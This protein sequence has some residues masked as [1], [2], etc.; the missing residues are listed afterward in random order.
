MHDIDKSIDTILS[1]FEQS[2]WNHSP[3]FS[4][5]KDLP[6]LTREKIRTIP[7][8]KGLYTSK[9]SGSTGEPVSIEKTLD[10]YVWYQATNIR[11]LIWRRWNFSKN[12]AVI[13][14]DS[15]PKPELPSWGISSRIA[16]KQGK[17]FYFN[18]APIDQ[19]QKWLEEKNP[20]YIQCLPSIFRQLDISKISNFID[21]KGTGEMGASM[22]SSEECGTIAIQ[23]PDNKNNYH[24]ME[25]QIVETDSDGAILI[26]TLTNPYIRRYKHGDHV[27]LGTCSCGRTLQT[28]TQING[29]VRNMFVMPDGSKKWPIFGSRTYYE[30]YGILRYKLIQKTILD[31]EMQ[32][33][34]PKLSCDKE[35][36]LLSEVRHL[37]GV[38][39]HLTFEYVDGFSDYKFEEFVSLV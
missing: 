20:H 23:C 32:L 2:Q 8:K 9:T 15:P 10:D 3:K 21:W 4:S 6:I 14:G 22:Y 37:L 18:F 24:V 31:L 12:L 27:V 7:M 5:I 28:I 35:Y 13:R 38:P 26:S 34:A 33:I 29:R 16:P 17:C 25:N 1:L 11:E 36:E 30:K 39:I 19:I